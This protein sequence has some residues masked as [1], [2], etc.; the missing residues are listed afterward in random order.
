MLIEHVRKRML[1]ISPS[2]MISAS[3]SQWFIEDAEPRLDTG[4]T[5]SQ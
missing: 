4:S 2:K 3:D 5:P 1:Q